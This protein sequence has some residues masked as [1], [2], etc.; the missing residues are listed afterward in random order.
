MSSA[1]VVAPHLEHQKKISRPPL[2]VVPRGFA[3]ML[4]LSKLMAKAGQ[5]S[6]SGSYRLEQKPSERRLGNW[7]T[8]TIGS[9]RPSTGSGAESG[10]SR[11][12]APDSSSRRT[13]RASVGSSARTFGAR[14]T[15]PPDVLVTS[16]GRRL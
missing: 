7:A 8:S 4:R 16:S 11:H 12:G 9:V 3:E 1:L 13:G 10:L 5:V 14:R 6:A 2:S 15:L